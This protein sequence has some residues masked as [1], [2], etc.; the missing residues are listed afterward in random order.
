MVNRNSWYSQ[1]NGSET[2]ATQIIPPRLWGPMTGLKD[3]VFK[4][5]KAK[6]AAD[7]L[8]TKT[9]LLRYVGT[10]SFHRAAM[11]LRLLNK[12]EVMEFKKPDRQKNLKFEDDLKESERLLQASNYQLD[13]MEY[14]EQVKAHKA[15]E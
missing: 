10:Q 9:K 3:V 6:E 13:V 11:T 4:A 7:F 5:G 12:M 1:G 14:N 8:D 2:S 15:Y